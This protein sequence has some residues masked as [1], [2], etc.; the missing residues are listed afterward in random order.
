MADLLSGLSQL[1]IEPLAAELRRAAQGAVDEASVRRGRDWVEAAQREFPLA[2]RF[3]DSLINAEPAAV[4]RDLQKMGAFYGIDLKGLKGNQSVLNY[5]RE[6]QTR[7]RKKR[8]PTE[9][10]K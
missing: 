2:S 10:G 8:L 4:V 6:L 5:I 1:L 9:V 7:L 3:I